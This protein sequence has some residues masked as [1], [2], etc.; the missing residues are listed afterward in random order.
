[1]C[2]NRLKY[3]LKITITQL[4]LKFLGDILSILLLKL[5][6]LESFQVQ[7]IIFCNFLECTFVKFSY[8]L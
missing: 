2:Q 8:N 3:S 1:M 5:Q 7:Q 4:K 6:T